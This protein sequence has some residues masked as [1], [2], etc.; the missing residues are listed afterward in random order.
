ML[1]SQPCQRVFCASSS[2]SLSFLLSTDLVNAIPH[3]WWDR[4]IL[5]CH[6][7]GFFWMLDA[8][9][10]GSPVETRVLS[11]FGEKVPGHRE[12]SQNQAHPGWLRCAPMQRHPR[13]MVWS[14]AK[15]LRPWGPRGGIFQ[16]QSFPVKPKWTPGEEKHPNH[17][18]SLAVNRRGWE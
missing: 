10:Q 3:H 13:Y 14:P 15:A 7:H 16:R 6:P 5:A 11:Y 18:S 12:G 8:Q 9:D 1:N 4:V 2:P 17:P